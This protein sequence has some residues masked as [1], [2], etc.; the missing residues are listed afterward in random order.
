MFLKIS[1]NVELNFYGPKIEILIGFLVE[2]GG[3]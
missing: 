1:L 3:L 2:F